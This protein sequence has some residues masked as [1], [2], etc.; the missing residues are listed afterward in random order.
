MGDTSAVG[1]WHTPRAFDG[2]F[3]AQIAMERQIGAVAAFCRA[4]CVW[5]CEE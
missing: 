1:A 3:R 5:Q 2:A 4:Y